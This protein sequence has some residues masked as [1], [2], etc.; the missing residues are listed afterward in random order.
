MLA[1]LYPELRPR[2][3]TLREIQE[4]VCAAFGVSLEQL[5]SS[6]RA[7]AVAWPRQ[8]AMYLARELTDA[9]LPTIGREF[10]GRSHTT[11]LHAHRRTAERIASDPDAYETVRRITSDLRG[12]TR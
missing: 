7:T 10:G 3:R 8:V 4:E 9:T 1:G 5:I 12:G 11:V 6:S 2:R